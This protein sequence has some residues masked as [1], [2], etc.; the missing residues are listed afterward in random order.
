MRILLHQFFYLNVV[1][2]HS[3]IQECEYPEGY[4][5]FIQLCP[6]ENRFFLLILASQYFVKTK[7]ISHFKKKRV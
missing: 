5:T 1:I 2:S 6:F 3:D 4:L 7:F